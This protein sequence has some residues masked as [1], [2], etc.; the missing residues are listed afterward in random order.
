MGRDRPLGVSHGCRSEIRD[1]PQASPKSEIRMTN[2]I[3]NSKFEFQPSNL[4]RHSSFEFR[5]SA[6]RLDSSFEFRISDLSRPPA[7]VRISTR[8]PIVHSGI[9]PLLGG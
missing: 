6:Q 7:K 4:I 1:L 3:R 5:V 9:G 8:V 2:Q